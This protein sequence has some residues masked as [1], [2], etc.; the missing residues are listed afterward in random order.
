[1]LPYS[2]RLALRHFSRKRIYSVII[3]LS[4]TAGFACTCLLVSFLIAETNADSFH[5][6]KDR[7]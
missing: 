6:N 2:L 1:M 5:P 4:L 3:V 7:T